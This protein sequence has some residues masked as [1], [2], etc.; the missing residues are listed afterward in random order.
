M[1]TAYDGLAAGWEDQAGRVYRPLAEA[2]VC[3]APLPLAGRRVL[4]AG[5]GTGLVAAAA[6]RRGARVVVVDQAIGMLQFQGGR[7]GPGAAADVL[8]LPF[9]AGS[10]DIALAGFVINH[11]VPSTGLARLAHVVRPGGAVVA[12]TWVRDVPDAVK[13]A[14][15]RVVAEWG[16]RP[17]AWY[18]AMKNELD[19]VSGSAERLSAAAREAGLVDVRVSA[20]AHDLGMLKPGDAVAYRLAL[21]QLAAWAVGLN[22]SARATLFQAA[23]EAVAPHIAAWRPAMILLTGFVTAPV[24][25]SSRAA[26]AVRVPA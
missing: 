3:A 7:Q 1:T 5:S 2:L 20:A 10:F 17:P 24:Q 12:S 6:K 23:C 4:D 18:L 14:V 21:P 25:P 22:E 13:V 8:A 9:R 11:V 19:P 15:D 26:A 16:W